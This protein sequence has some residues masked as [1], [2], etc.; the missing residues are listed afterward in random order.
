MRP[1]LD[2]TV[3]VHYGQM[4]LLNRDS[5]FDGDLSASFRGQSNGLLGAARP[6]LLFLITGRH[7]GEVGL[8]IELHEQE[9]PLGEDWP[10]V[11]EAS[12]QLTGD[13]PVLSE[14]GERWYALDLPPGEYRIRYCAQGM[15]AANDAITE[16]GV[17]DRYLLQLW[18]AEPAPDA[19]RRQTS[20]NAAYWHAEARK[21]PPPPTPAELAAEE[22]R[23]SAEEQVRAALR[24]RQ[25]DIRRW[26]GEPPSPALRHLKGNARKVIREHREVAEA[27]A[28]AA[29]AAQRD[30]AAGLARQACAA[31][32]LTTLDWITGA[33]A[34]VDRGEEPFTDWRVAGERLLADPGVPSTVAFPGGLRQQTAAFATLRLAV[35]PDPLA[36]AL[37]TLSATLSTVGPEH[38]DGLL[39][40]V[41][42]TL[43]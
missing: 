11:V 7:T 15:D 39:A 8:T 43:S 33:L 18:P 17:V 38:R 27:L 25:E 32:G 22:A 42:H 23:R 9:P 5:P 6:E 37:E 35:L 34:A 4:Y 16:D 31:A 12:C 21:L 30:L 24:Q 3:S 1:L 20:K 14:W 41:R 29:P 10:D 19:V 26:G 13:D 36:A 40:Q 2:H 28:A